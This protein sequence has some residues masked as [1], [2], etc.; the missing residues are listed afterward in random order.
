MS[1]ASQDSDLFW[2]LQAGR[3]RA[4]LRLGREFD[5]LACFEQ[6][7][8]AA[9]QTRHASLGYDLD[10]A[11]LRERRGLFDVTVELAASLGEGEVCVEGVIDAVKAWTLTCL[12]RMRHV[13]TAP[14]KELPELE[15]INTLIDGIELLIS[16][17]QTVTA[18]AELATTLQKY[19]ADRQDLVDRH[20]RD[21]SRWALLGHAQDLDVSLLS[22][23]LGSQRQTA[24]SYFVTQSQIVA[25][26][27]DGDGCE[28]G[29]RERSE[30]LEPP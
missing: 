1:E 20:R 12:L 18:R 10:N 24:L 28:V 13:S 6:G 19:L 14:R 23:A 11:A 27:I 26:L 16:Q 2:R 30:V 17:A 22:R 25:V 7:C 15:Q 21:D 4:M 29:T 3:G 9:L 5:A 8:S